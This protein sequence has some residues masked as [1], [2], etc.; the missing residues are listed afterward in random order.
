MSGFIILLDRSIRLGNLV[1][2]DQNV[3]GTVAQIT[4]RYTVLKMLNGTEVIIP[5]EYLVNNIVRNQS[6][7][8][9]RVRIGVPIQV[10][11]GTDLEEAMALMIDA[12]KQQPRVLAD[13]EPGVQLVE[14]A[15]SG[16]NL[17]LG[18]WMNDPEQG[19][20]GVRSDINM[21]IWRA[22]RANAIEIPF[23]QC[24]VRLI[25]GAMPAAD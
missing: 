11:Y 22:F 20:G 8:D 19:T 4:T 24:E 3:S 25:G 23:P 12:A 17:E 16:I 10:A 5:N 15:A 13:P 14:F 9:T 21:A 18:F 1:T 7:T 2:V 6:F